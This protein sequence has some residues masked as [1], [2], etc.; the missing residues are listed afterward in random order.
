MAK[1]K[2]STKKD[3]QPRNRASVTFIR[4]SE[5]W[6]QHVEDLANQDRC[7]SVSEFIDRAIAFYARSRGFN[8]PPMR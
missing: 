7:T 5:E 4:S 3:P 1:P 6:K 2:A 8:P